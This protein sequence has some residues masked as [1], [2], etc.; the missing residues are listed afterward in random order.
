MGSDTGIRSSRSGSVLVPGCTMSLTLQFR[1]S[2]QQELFPSAIEARLTI[3]PH[4]SSYVS[5]KG[6]YRQLT[7]AR[8]RGLLETVSGAI[9]KG[10][11]S[12]Q[13]K[14]PWYLGKLPFK[15]LPSDCY[16]MA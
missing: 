16:R 10:M 6:D 7:G 9:R 14:S 1:A 11:R 15:Y 4:P 8:R 3:W 2:V 13:R 5:P 12:L